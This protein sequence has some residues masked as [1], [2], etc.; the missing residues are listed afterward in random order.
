MSDLKHKKGKKVSLFSCHLTVGDESDGDSEVKTQNVASVGKGGGDCCGSYYFMPG[1]QYPNK[2][3]S[4]NI[5]CQTRNI[6]WMLRM[7]P[8]VQS[9]IIFLSCIMVM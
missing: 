9:Q 3:T 5:C 8:T 2:V 1:Y 7:N 4:N 6:L